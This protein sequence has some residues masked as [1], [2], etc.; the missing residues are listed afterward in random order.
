M[1]WCDDCSIGEVGSIQQYQHAHRQRLFA[2]HRSWSAVGS[3][4]STPEKINKRS[5]SGS[6]WFVYGYHLQ[7]RHRK[8]FSR[9]DQKETD[10][11]DFGSET[12]TE[13][14]VFLPRCMECRRALAMRKLSVRPSVCPSVKLVICDKMKD[15]C[16]YFLI[17]HERSFTLV[18]WQEEWLM[19]TT[20]SSW[21]CKS[22]WPRWSEIADFRSMFS[23]SASAVHL[24]NMFN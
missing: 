8:V 21:N 19:G 5:R 3:D 22:N 18:L 13:I 6:T 17:P 16:A 10:A 1:C 12:E 24:A 23:H 2:N 20:P 14:H 11:F 4:R 7:H 9:N 15:L